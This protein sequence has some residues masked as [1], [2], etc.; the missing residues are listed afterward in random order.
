LLSQP[1]FGA[2]LKLYASPWFGLQLMVR[3]T[4]TYIESDP[5]G[6]WRSLFWPGVCRVIADGQHSHEF[7]LSGGSIR[8][9][10]PF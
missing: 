6:L 10:Q 3:W 4:P 5:A 8:P 2:G 9:S 1:D 7:E